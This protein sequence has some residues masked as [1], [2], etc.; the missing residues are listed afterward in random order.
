QINNS[1]AIV[2]E[3]GS[4]KSLTLKSILGLLPQNLSYTFDYSCEF[5][6]IKG[7]TL[8]YIPQNPFTALSPLTKIKNQFFGDINFFVYL[9]EFL[10]IGNFV[11]NRYPSE[12]S[13]GQLQRVIIA[14]SLTENTKMILLDE[15][16]TALD[17]DTKIG[18]IELLQKLKQKLNFLLLFVTHEI[19]IIKNLCNDTIVLNRGKIVEFG[20]TIN[21]LEN[22]SHE[23]TKKL[24][25]SSFTNRE[26]RR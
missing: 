19:N 18:V 4:G 20:N 25:N 16:T 26:F 17:S 15:P 7:Q 24:I 5:E 1:L 11:L 12:L 8:A 3:S 6:L 9:L 2:G 21:L 23:Y 10:G 22:P 14:M 13:G